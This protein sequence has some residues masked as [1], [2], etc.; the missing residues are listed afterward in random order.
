MNYQRIY[1]QIVGRAQNRKL[2]G[3]KE[4]HHILPKCLGGTNEKDNLVE[5][6]AREH[7]LCHMLLVEI[8]PK[9]LKLKQ[10]LWLMAIGK[11]KKEKYIVSSRIYEHIKINRVVWWGDK[12]S[13]S[14]KGK[15]KKKATQETKDKISKAL[16]NKYKHSE[17]FKNNIKLF[18]IGRIFSDE[19]KLKMSESH[20]GKII[21][22]ETKLKMSLSR[23][24][25]VITDETKQKIS[26]SMLGK[27]KTEEHKEN[28]R[29]CRL[30]KPTK[31]AIPVI[32]YDLEGN[33][34]QEWDKIVDILNY[35][36]KTKND[37][38]I[39]QCCKGRTKTAFGYKWGYKL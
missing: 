33:F 19:T 39:T 37:S 7:F 27:K 28:M 8:Y 32:Q 35:F 25:V 18:H 21:T 14:N 26:N 29:L 15:P 1:D 12:I 2:E 11:N 10:A 16:K 3:Y 31:K 36:Q 34:I 22:D 20:K 5:L 38:G 13:K 30:N 9:E 17:E 24:N 23:A 4:K 6:T